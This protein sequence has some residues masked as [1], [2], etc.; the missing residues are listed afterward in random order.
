MHSWV[1]RQGKE[2]KHL[3][4]GKEKT[5][6]SPHATRTVL[7]KVYQNTIRKHMEMTINSSSIQRYRLNLQ[8]S[9]AFL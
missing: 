7:Q 9:I 2:I 6:L 8:I 4:M 3:Q 5:K 1:K